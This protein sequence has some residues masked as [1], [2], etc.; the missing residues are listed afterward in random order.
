MKTQ[1]RA[2]VTLLLLTNMSCS[3]PKQIAKN[4]YSHKTECIDMEL[5]G[6][7]IVN[8]WSNN[9]EISTAIEQAKRNAVHAVLFEVLAG[10]ATCNSA[11]ILPNINVKSQNEVYFNNFFAPGGDYIKYAFFKDE[12]AYQTFTKDNESA[13]RM[14]N[15]GFVI[16]VKRQDLKQKMIADG[17]LKP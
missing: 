16:R 4:Y 17:I 11:P 2:I 1:I 9:D 15:S 5:D 10:K 7:Q 8:A 12:S 3:T 13:K 14:I 6:N